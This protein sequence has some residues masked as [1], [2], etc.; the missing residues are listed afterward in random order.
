MI[1]WTEVPLDYEPLTGS[2]DVFV[3]ATS[4]FQASSLGKNTPARNRERQAHFERQLKNIAWHLGSRN[5][6]VFL[7]FNGER[8]RMDKGCIGLAVT[9]GILEHPV[10]G[11]EDFVTHV[12]LTAEP[13]T[14]F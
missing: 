1:S 11:P 2:N 12:T 6:P 7:S 8:R 4:V 9:A 10:D 3:V 5:V 13:P 14:P